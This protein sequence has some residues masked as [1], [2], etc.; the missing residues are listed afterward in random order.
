MVKIIRKI[1]IVDV[2]VICIIGAAAYIRLYDLNNLGFGW[3]DLDH[4]V[5]RS[6]PKKDLWEIIRDSYVDAHPPI[7][8]VI[9]HLITQVTMDPFWLR[10]VAWVPGI[11]LLPLVYIWLWR[12]FDSRLAGAIGVTIAGFSYEL[13][14]L[15]MSTRP[16]MLFG[17][18]MVGYLICWQQSFQ[19]RSMRWAWLLV[20]FGSLSSLT[21]YGAVVYLIPAILISG[22]SFYV[23]SKKNHWLTLKYLIINSIPLVILGLQFLL[24]Q[25]SN[26][27]YV[28][29]LANSNRFKVRSIG[30]PGVFDILSKTFNSFT[31]EF[32]LFPQA[33]LCLWLFGL[34]LLA[35]HRRTALCSLCCLTVGTNVLLSFFQCYP[36]FNSRHLLPVFLAGLASISY[37]L[38]CI[39]DLGRNSRFGSLWKSFFLIAA[40]CSVSTASVFYETPSQHMLQ[41]H[42]RPYWYSGIDTREMPDFIEAHARSGDRLLVGETLLRLLKLKQ[43][44]IKE[45]FDGLPPM[46]KFPTRYRGILTSRMDSASKLEFRNYLATNCEAKDSTRFW[47][48]YCNSAGPLKKLDSWIINHNSLLLLRKT[49]D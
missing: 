20:L 19:V 1:S 44:N 30:V 5:R 36:F 40:A 46:C 28:E 3:D 47:C 4:I 34:L 23:S 48:L 31:F 8:N 43:V 38:L 10:S 21:H 12:I 13:I 15:S 39:A 32:E 18:F 25:Y 7:R 16:Y 42:R 49:V 2:L 9:L 14:S 6:N 26:E 17:C 11:M 27:R 29:G 41:N 37:A 33:L 45:Y 22:F 24:I 35:L